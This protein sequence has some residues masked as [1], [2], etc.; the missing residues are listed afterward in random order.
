MWAKIL[1]TNDNPSY[2]LG[3]NCLLNICMFDD[4]INQSHP[5]I[6]IEYLTFDQMVACV[7]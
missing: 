5:H 4:N 7:L 6:T 1:S 2:T 3:T